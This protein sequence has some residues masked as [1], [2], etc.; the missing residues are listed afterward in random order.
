MMTEAMN[1]ENH[2]FKLSINSSGIYWQRIFI[3]VY[4]SV[5]HSEKRQRNILFSVLLICT[6]SIYLGLPAENG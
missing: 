1:F 3:A 6:E 5:A 2:K 4:E